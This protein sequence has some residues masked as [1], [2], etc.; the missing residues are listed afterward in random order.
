M[1]SDVDNRW[2]AYDP[3]VSTGSAV[4]FS[5][6]RSAPSPWAEW[7]VLNF[8]HRAPQRP[9]PLG[10]TADTCFG[11]HR[12]G[13]GSARL[14][15]RNLRP[16]DDTFAGR[17]VRGSSNALGTLKGRSGNSE[18]V[19]V[20]SLPVGNFARYAYPGD[21]VPR[22]AKSVFWLTLGEGAAYVNRF[23]LQFPVFMHFPDD[24]SRTSTQPRLAALEKQSGS[25]SLI[26][27]TGR[28]Q[29]HGD[30]GGTQ[31]PRQ[32]PGIDRDAV[33]VNAYFGDAGRNG[34]YDSFDVQQASRMALR[35]DTGFQQ[36][37]LLDPTILADFN[38]NGRLDS[39]DVQQLSRLALRLPVTGVADLPSPAPTTTDTDR[40]VEDPPKLAPA[41]SSSAPR[42]DVDGSGAVDA[43]DVAWAVYYFNRSENGVAPAESQGKNL[44]LNGDQSFDAADVLLAVTDLNTQ[45]ASAEGEST[46]ATTKDGETEEDLDSLTSLL[47][48]DL[49][50]SRK[51][52]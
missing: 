21:H 34:K 17:F 25:P 18:D 24:A 44:D 10:F 15:N 20:S 2:N 32:Y 7:L 27:N 12:R 36:H 45:S 38:G 8:F 3:Q 22:R 41:K 30:G 4:A 26:G 33:H 6:C 47:A 48:E 51:K 29:P 14:N 39:F 35:L 28:P 19:A 42:S 16:T 5:V 23:D 46:S 31:R 13:I 40:L 1:R 43:Q 49:V 9:R 52:K 37:P 11:W 50:A